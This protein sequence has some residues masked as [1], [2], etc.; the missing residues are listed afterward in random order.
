MRRGVNTAGKRTAKSSSFLTFLSRQRQ[1][2]QSWAIFLG[3][4]ALM[5]ALN[6]W[7]SDWVNRIA[8]EWTADALGWTL[9]VL[10]E[11]AT[12]SGVF[13]SCAKCNFQI[14][15]ECTAFFPISILIAAVLAAPVAWRAKLLGIALGAPILY[16]INLVRLV[17][18][19]FIHRS[20][21]QAFETL[22]LLVWQSL[23][24]FLTLLLWIVWFLFVTERD[25]VAEAPTPKARR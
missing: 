23:M 18:L 14:I 4:L 24:I 20:Y 25:R 11:K 8:A 21:P 9:G 17:M 2:I 16:L 5:V 13:V 10:G 6:E 1:L 7:K 3:V 12:V 15:G 22:H 19:C